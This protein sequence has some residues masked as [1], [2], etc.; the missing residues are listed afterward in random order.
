MTGVATRIKK[1]WAIIGGTITGIGAVFSVLDILPKLVSSFENAWTLNFIPDVLLVMGLT[2]LAGVAYAQFGRGIAS[3]YADVLR[4]GSWWQRAS[5]VLLS[6]VVLGLV[7]TSYGD[8]KK[9]YR[10]RV[11][12]A[13]FDWGYVRAR[14]ALKRGEFITAAALLK[15]DRGTQKFLS[16]ALKKKR[17]QEEADTLQRLVDVSKY[18]KRY[19]QAAAVAPISLPDLL[20]LQ[21]A[22]RLYPDSTDVLSTTGDAQR[23]LQAAV[24]FWLVGVGALQDGNVSLAGERFRRSHEKGGVSLFDQELLLRYCSQ[25][26]LRHF[27][28]AEAEVLNGYLHIPVQRLRFLLIDTHPWVRALVALP[29]APMAG[30]G[31]SQLSYYEQTVQRDHGAVPS[32]FAPE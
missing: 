25:P 21:R 15:S 12:S 2:L 19:R 28:A 32:A 30:T 4:C 23:R 8:W 3:S 31:A 27:S 1:R 11:S 7:A 24:G 14:S 20:L 13:K 17:D 26:D 9:Y 6:L 22:A 16:T 5:L 10:Q 18:L 29:S